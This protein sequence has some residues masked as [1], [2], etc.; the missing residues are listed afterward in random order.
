MPRSWARDQSCEFARQ[1]SRVRRRSDGGRGPSLLGREE[2]LHNS[3]KR[4]HVARVTE[5]RSC[6]LRLGVSQ[7]GLSDRLGL[8]LNSLRMWDSGLRPTP[9]EILELVR[10]AVAEAIGRTNQSTCWA[11]KPSAHINPRARSSVG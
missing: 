3:P 6:R 11:N 8:P 1:N 10:I 4:W 2:A 7:A 9:D 5:L